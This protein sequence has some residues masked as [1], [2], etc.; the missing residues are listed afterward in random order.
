MI[1]KSSTEFFSDQVVLTDDTKS[2]IFASVAKGFSSPLPYYISK[3]EEHLSAMKELASKHTDINPRV[4]WDA[5]RL[6]MKVVGTKTWSQ[7]KIAAFNAAAEAEKDEVSQLRLLVAK[8]PG[9]AVAALGY[10]LEANKAVASQLGD[11]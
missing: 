1:T 8:Y 10:M 5:S 7:E 3:V 6:Q 2:D 11:E 9:K 4:S